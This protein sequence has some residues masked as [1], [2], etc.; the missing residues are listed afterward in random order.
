MKSFPKYR[1]PVL[2]GWILPPIL[3]FFILREIPIH[4]ILKIVLFPLLAIGFVFAEALIG[5]KIVG[6]WNR[7]QERKEKKTRR[8]KR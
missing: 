3:S 6:V 1:I 2:I 5:M 4:L 8:E 7:W